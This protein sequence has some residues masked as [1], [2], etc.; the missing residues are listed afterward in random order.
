MPRVRDESSF[1]Q[2]REKILAVATQCF[3]ETGFHGTGMAKICQAAG[4]S[5]GALY[6]YFP[7]KESMIESIVEQDRKYTVF[8]L[9]KIQQSE[10]KA[11]GLAAMMAEAVHMLANDR[12]YCQLC[13]E[14]S[15][16][17]SRNVA[18]ANLLLSA[19]AELLEVLTAAVQQGQEMGHI[20]PT[21]APKVTAQLLLTL[22]DGFIGQFATK[23]NLKG[24]AIAQHAEQMVLQLLSV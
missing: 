9:E 3:I 20:K 1:S 10:N 23:S 19:E 7:S 24:K 5:A 21:L 18:V 16:E 11:T 22:G 17:A 4:M 12:S 2:K 13:V 8:L 14:I 15:A 6:R